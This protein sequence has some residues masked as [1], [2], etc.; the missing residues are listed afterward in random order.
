VPAEQHQPIWIG[1][2]IDMASY[3]QPALLL[4]RAPAMLEGGYALTSVAER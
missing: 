4:A 3:D 2:E 1:D